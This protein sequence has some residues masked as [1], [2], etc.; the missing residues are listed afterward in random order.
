VVFAF[1]ILLNHYLAFSTQHYHAIQRLF[2][3]Y[4]QVENF[5]LLP[6][7]TNVSHS[8]EQR[9]AMLAQGLAQL[10]KREGFKGQAHLVTNS[11]CG[12][13]AR[14]AIS[15]YG[16]NTHVRSLTTICSPHKGMRL[17]DNCSRMPERYLIEDC[18]KAF[19]AVGLSQKSA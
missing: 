11:F 18:E 7:V 14:A 17:V 9:G 3:T 10:A 8:L 5:Y 6:N 16:A 2:Q 13:D 1:N 12:V 15:L 19:E 4:N